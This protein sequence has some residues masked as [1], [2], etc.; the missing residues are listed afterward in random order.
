MY[1]NQCEPSGDQTVIPSSAAGET[2]GPGAYAHVPASV[3]HGITAVG[4]DGCTVLYLYLRDD[5]PAAG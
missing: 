1:S 5:G 3:E 4:D 2:V